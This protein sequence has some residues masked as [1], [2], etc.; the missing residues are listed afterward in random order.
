MLSEIHHKIS[1]DGSNLSDQSEDKLTGDVFGALR[2]L[3]FSK[4]LKT[5]LKA[6]EWRPES[7]RSEFESLIEQVGEH[8][9]PGLLRFWPWEPPVEPDLTFETKHFHC[10][11]EVKYNSDLSGEDQLVKQSDVMAKKEPR[12][13]KFLILLGRQEKLSTISEGDNF[14]KQ[15]RFGTLSWQA[16]YRQLNDVKRDGPLGFPYDYILDDIL[17]LLEKKGFDPF[18]GFEIKSGMRVERSFWHFQSDIPSFGFTF[19]QPVH[20]EQCF[21]FEIE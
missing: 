10:W 3:P 11:I 1:A 6:V 4:G 14:H 13:P 12:I 20:D 16:V 15:V 8:A 17:K 2:Y 9:V 19:S 18:Y 21:R 5:V 7:H